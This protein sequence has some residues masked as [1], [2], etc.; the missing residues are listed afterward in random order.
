MKRRERG[1][2]NPSKMIKMALLRVAIVPYCN[3]RIQFS[4]HLHQSDPY[5]IILE[6]GREELY[7][8]VEQWPAGR[9]W[10][11]KTWLA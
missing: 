4:T 1:M 9:L 6:D 8:T 10:S 5:S 3:P 7:Q 11:A 2:I